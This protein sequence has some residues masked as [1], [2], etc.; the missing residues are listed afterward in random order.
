M[1]AILGRGT[2]CLVL[3]LV[4]L[5]MLGDE[6]MISG[7]MNSWQDRKFIAG[8]IRPSFLSLAFYGNEAS[9]M[10]LMI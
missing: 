5:Y 7:L 4:L 3:L 9:R 8:C 1:V 6:K 10:P 2:L